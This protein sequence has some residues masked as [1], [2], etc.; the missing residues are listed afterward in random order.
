MA[1]MGTGNIYFDLTE[2]LNAEGDIAAED[3]L[4]RN[5]LVQEASDGT[6]Q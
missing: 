2:E 3:L 4:P 1:A 5:P 6:A